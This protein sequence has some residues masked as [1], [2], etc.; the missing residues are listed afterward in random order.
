[1]KFIQILI[2]TCFYC[3]SF[4]ISAKTQSLELIPS[5]EIE[6]ID[7][8]NSIFQTSFSEFKS[9][10][11]IFVF[12]SDDPAIVSGYSIKDGKQLFY[13]DL[14]GSGPHE[15]QYLV[16]L[17]ITDDT[18]YL[19]S[20]DGKVI[21][22]DFLGEPVFETL[23]KFP[24]AKDIIKFNTQLIIASESPAFTHYVQKT[25]LKNDES[26]IIEIEQKF[27]NLLM[28]RF[29]D[30]GTLTK[31]NNMLYVTEPYGNAVY[32][33][34]NDD[35]K[36]TET[37]YLTIPDFK[38]GIMKRD[39][40]LYLSDMQILRSFLMEN[41]TITGFYP[42]GDDYLIEVF[43]AHENLNRRDILLMDNHFNLQCYS[44]LPKSI[45]GVENPK[46][47]FSDGEFL[48]FYREEIDHGKN[49]VRKFISS[50]KPVCS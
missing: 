41:S 46:I 34:S 38:I 22:L 6:L 45:M 44:T 10:G 8:I 9:N 16:N 18:V 2:I 40:E 47:H 3:L 48:Y 42:L 35:F 11:K 20:R 23:T 15:T 37:I 7:S 19:I 21:G 25:H 28:S 13:K 14:S 24:M 26:S 36:V 1:M 32:K 5:D 33:V 31:N 30:S 39:R 4:S 12:I 27:E 49:Q 17:D 43:H 50:Y 29:R